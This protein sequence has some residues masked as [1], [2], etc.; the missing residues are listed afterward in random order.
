MSRFS[1]TRSGRRALALSLA[2]LLLGLLLSTVPSP[3][4]AQEP[5]GAPAASVRG[6]PTASGWQLGALVDVGVPD[7][8]GVSLVVRPWHW[9]R[10]HGG[11]TTNAVSFGLRGGAT[12]VPFHAWISPSL[13][14]EGG[15]VFEGDA[16][17]LT[18]SFGLTSPMLEQ[19]GYSYG[20][21]HL[22]LELGSPDSVVFF[23]HAGFSALHTTLH[24]A[25][26]V[27][28]EELE[29][30][31]LSFADPKVSALVPSAKLGLLVFF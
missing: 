13:T 9:L 4:S 8:L 2:S 28:R 19:V 22:G 20:N 29:Q 3:V 24:Q 6:A 18:E 14:V 26:E 10:L 5:S 31:S 17:T 11:A 1:R 27:L 12:L 30:P 25:D 7:L 16:N 15:Y 23:V 21:A